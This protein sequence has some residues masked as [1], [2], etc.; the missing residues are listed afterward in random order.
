MNKEVE[1][2]VQRDKIIKKSTPIDVEKISAGFNLQ[3]ELSKL[4]ISVPFNELLRNTEYRDTIT[5]MVK[6]QGEWQSDILELNDDN[7]A[8]SFGSKVENMEGEEVPPFYLSLN[9]HDKVVHNA[10]LD[11]GA[12]H[13]LM[14]KGVVESLGLEVTRPYKYLYSFDSKRVKCL[15][16]I[17]DMVVTLN[18]LPSKTIVMDVVVAYIPPKFEVLLSRS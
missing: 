12:S 17:K 15:G 2:E 9:V 7:P 3:N 8:I 14:P 13:N 4:K 16:L 18:K 11:S 10:M 1:N 5:K 6:N